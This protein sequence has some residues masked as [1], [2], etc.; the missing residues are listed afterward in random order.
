MRGSP[1]TSGSR[2][3]I[4]REELE[5]KPVLKLVQEVLITRNR[6]QTQIDLGLPDTPPGPAP[7][8]RPVPPTRRESGSPRG[9]P[10]LR[11]ERPPTP[12]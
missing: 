1:S 7:P 8:R 2:V 12:P 6:Q 4:L 5:S 10:Y 11:P 3:N 9:P